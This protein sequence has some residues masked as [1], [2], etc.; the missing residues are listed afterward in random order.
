MRFIS[1]W[2]LYTLIYFIVIIININWQYLSTK[3]S[4]WIIWKVITVCYWVSYACHVCYECVFAWIRIFSNKEDPIGCLG[5]WALAHDSY[6]QML[7]SLSLEAN[8]VYN[9]FNFIHVIYRLGLGS[10]KF[11]VFDDYVDRS[12]KVV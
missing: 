7:N 9:I 4:E 11:K 10:V 8:P 5:V 2:K 6:K 1:E 3:Y 12:I